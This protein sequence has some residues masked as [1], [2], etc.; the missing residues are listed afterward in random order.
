MLKYK[1]GTRIGPNNILFLEDYSIKKDNGKTVRMGKFQC[2]Y[3]GKIFEA[4]PSSIGLGLTKSCGCLHKRTSR[5][6]TFK[7]LTGQRF[8]K[9][10]VESCLPESTKDGRAIWHCKCDCGNYKDVCTKFLT[11]GHVISCGC[12]NSK[13]EVAVK[14]ILDKKCIKYIQQYKIDIR[15]FDFYLP[16]YNCCIEYD[17]IQHYKATNSKW[18][19]PAHLKEQQRIDKEKNQLCLKSNLSIIRIPYFEYQQLNENTLEQLLNEVKNGKLPQ[20]YTFGE[21]G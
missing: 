13:G 12:A 11:S 2:P 18:N 9:L 7:D 19:T 14:N 4:V 3:D 20:L 1:V 10:V 21:I 16:D 15:Y 17:G 5:A 8:G 6:R